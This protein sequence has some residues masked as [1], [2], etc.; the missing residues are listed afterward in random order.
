MLHMRRSKEKY[1]HHR[2]KAI[3]EKADLQKKVFS[4]K[5]KGAWNM[6][7]KLNS[8]GAPPLI[9]VT[10]LERGPQGQAA[11]TV[12]T[13]PQEVDAIIRKAY[14]KIYKG[15]S[16][17]Q[18]ALMEKYF[19]DYDKFI[20]KMPEAEV[21]DITGMT[22]RRFAMRQSTQQREW[23]SGPQRTSRS[24]QTWPTSTWRT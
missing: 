15:N 7:K 16:S 20:F 24:C 9:A 21:E 4:S 22:S 3:K 12:A 10:R 23:T 1:E 2:A 19:K 14:G 13:A 17:D 11:G 6:G 18:Q 5:S 8:K